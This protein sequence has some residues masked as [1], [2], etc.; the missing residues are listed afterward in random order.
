MD[1]VPGS[2]GCRLQIAIVR[3]WLL[4]CQEA[5]HA[6]GESRHLSSCGALNQLQ[7]RHLLVKD[8]NYIM[9]TYATKQPACK[10]THRV[11]DC[12]PCEFPLVLEEN[13]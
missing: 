4:I 7:R 8:D 6:V 10:G 9:H 5:G 12:V 3:R 13:F 2:F 11:C 1:R